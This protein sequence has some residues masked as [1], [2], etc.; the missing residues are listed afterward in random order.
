MKHIYPPHP[1]GVK[2]AN[3]VVCP[4]DMPKFIEKLLSLDAA[5]YLLPGTEFGIAFGDGFAEWQEP[6]N[7]DYCTIIKRIP[8]R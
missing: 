2:H 4:N 3:R 8:L 5:K 7:R 1:Q 6:P